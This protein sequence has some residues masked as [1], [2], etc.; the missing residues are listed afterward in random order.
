MGELGTI[1]PRSFPSFFPSHS[2]LNRQSQPGL[3]L[4]AAGTAW[5]RFIPKHE[6]QF[7]MGVPSFVPIFDVMGP[8]LPFWEPGNVF[9]VT[10]GGRIPMRSSQFSRKVRFFLNIFP[11]FEPDPRIPMLSQEIGIDCSHRGAFDRLGLSRT[12]V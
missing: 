12:L 3:E 1:H 6:M 10:Q 8:V 9:L 4:G 11:S 2:Q 5:V 7:L